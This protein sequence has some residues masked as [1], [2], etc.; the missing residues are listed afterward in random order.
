MPSRLFSFVKIN[1]YLFGN[2]WQLICSTIVVLE[3]PHC[4]MMVDM[5]V[6]WKVS[7]AYTIYN[8]YS[9]SYKV[10]IMV[11]LAIVKLFFK[12]IHLHILHKLMCFF[13]ANSAISCPIQLLCRI[14]NSS[15]FTS[16]WQKIQ[17]VI[18]CK[19]KLLEIL[20]CYRIFFNFLK[21]IGNLCCLSTKATKI[22]WT[23]FCCLCGIQ[24]GSASVQQSVLMREERLRV[25]SLHS[26]CQLWWCVSPP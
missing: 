21:K 14:H 17:M 18:F 11:G 4:G 7:Y 13:F 6:F 15:S 16:S 9:I 23:T 10:Y 3:L 12:K 5:L 26:L 24:I 2:K 19:Q 22:N 20:W 1:S 8:I 25:D